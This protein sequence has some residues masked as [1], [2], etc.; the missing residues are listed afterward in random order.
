MF[1][2]LGGRLGWGLL[3][4][5]V[6]VCVLCLQGDSLDI[7]MARRVLA[8]MHADLKELVSRNWGSH[9]GSGASLSSLHAQRHPV[10]VLDFANMVTSKAEY[11]WFLGK[12]VKMVSGNAQSHVAVAS[13]ALSLSVCGF[14]FSNPHW[15]VA[16]GKAGRTG[17]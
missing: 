14:V 13:I 7:G 8:S 15:T 16:V 1:C 6:T 11:Q 4:M 2:C 12:L 17:S 10:T 3:A 9:V 5:Q